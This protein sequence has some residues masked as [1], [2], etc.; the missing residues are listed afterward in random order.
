MA[1]KHVNTGIHRYGDDL[2]LRI[3]INGRDHWLDQEEAR[4]LAKRMG[5]HD[6]ETAA[7]HD[8]AFLILD[9]AGLDAESD[10]EHLDEEED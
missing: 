7:F 9:F 1:Q 8:V 10:E 2:L 4:D 3:S 6:P 5:E